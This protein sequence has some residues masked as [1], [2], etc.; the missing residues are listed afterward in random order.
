MVK[1]VS[2][3]YPLLVPNGTYIYTANGCVRCKCDA[4]N[5]LIL[6]CEPS[7]LKPTNWSTC[8]SM[9]CNSSSIMYIGNNTTT[10]GS[11]NVTVC[12]YAGYAT[13]TIF[14]TLVTQPIPPVISGR[15]HDDAGKDS[16]MKARGG[17]GSLW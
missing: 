12:A 13:Q 9:Q 1:N 11:H 6:Q 10:S 4:T 17:F 15:T 7:K 2:L 14:T 3:D 16:S 8:P 5:N